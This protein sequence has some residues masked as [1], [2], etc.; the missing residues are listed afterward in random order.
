MTLPGWD[1]LTATQA[2]VA[3]GFLAGFDET[4]R[5]RR[6]LVVYLSGAH[7]YGFPSPDSDLDIKCVHVAPTAALVGMSPAAPA[8]DTLTVIE[9]VE[10]DYGS[11]E[12]APV[13][14]GCLK[15]NGNYLERLLGRMVLAED[16][17]LAALRPL[18]RAGLSRMVV[19]H[20]RGFA[21]SQHRALAQAM[22]AKKVLYVL[23]TALTGI[24]LLA[25][26]EMEIDL[27]RLVAHHPVDGVAELIAIK[28]R[29]ERVALAE[30][31]LARWS[32]E[33]A[34]VMTALDASVAT[35]VLPPAP[36]PD[37]IAALDAWLVDLRRRAF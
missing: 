3:R 37:A 20:Y 26:G 23:R 36:P 31:E 8:A 16:P 35:S 11:N 22:T 12:L 28:Q 4:P 19:S 32:A 21:F 30:A 27:T 25:T 18:V 34:R 5:H 7:A 14:R 29:G 17:E 33:M 2:A 10:L 6:H 13:L 1:A 9:G 15:G 24:H